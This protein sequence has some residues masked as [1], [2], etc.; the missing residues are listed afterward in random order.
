M[1]FVKN[2]GNHVHR[3]PQKQMKYKELEEELNRLNCLKTR[4]EITEKGLRL[5]D[6]LNHAL[7][8][9]QSNEKMGNDIQSSDPGIAIIHLKAMHGDIE[10]LIE[11]GYGQTLKIKVSRQ[12]TSIADY[13]I[14]PDGKPFIL[15]GIKS[16]WINERRLLPNLDDNEKK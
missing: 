15:E 16:G 1:N 7:Y 11:E 6:E 4:D 5:I 2:V 3:K 8:E 9:L 14:F 13:I 12:R 10:I